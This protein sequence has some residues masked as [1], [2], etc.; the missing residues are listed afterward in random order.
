MRF[1]WAAVTVALCY[2]VTRFVP[3]RLSR[4]EPTL[5][6]TGSDMREV[7]AWVARCTD[8]WRPEV[9]LS[10]HPVAYVDDGSLVI[11]LPLW[12]SLR[13]NELAAVMRDAQEVHNVTQVTRVV[14]G[15]RIVN[16]GLGWG[17]RGRRGGDAW[18]SRRL[19][20]RI[21]QR[22]A[23]FIECHRR[24]VESVRAR[25]GADWAAAAETAEIAVEAW[26]VLAEQWLEPAVR[27][28]VW[29][30]TPFTALTQFA[31]GCQDTGVVQRRH[32]RAPGP[33]AVGLLAHFRSYERALAEV[34]VADAAHGRVPRAWTE[35]PSAVTEPH[36]REQ[37]ALGL[38]AADR[39][40]GTP[41]P[42]TVDSLLTLLEQ[43]GATPSPRP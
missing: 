30:N 38:A 18:A 5:A 12:V 35:H 31:A 24:W 19:L 34:L 37:V 4:G 13:E 15:F 11:G 21:D 26:Q 8:G 40:T 25:R 36:W 10:P 6:L 29:H 39:A 2:N 3:R 16:G 1:L 28:G 22:V 43:G 7:S 20:G 23:D 9:R 33:D 32:S 17:L 42:A 27:C 14:R 41:R